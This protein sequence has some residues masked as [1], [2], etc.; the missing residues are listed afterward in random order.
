MV[1]K[2]RAVILIACEAVRSPAVP[3]L[4]APAAVN[5]QTRTRTAENIALAGALL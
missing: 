3:V 5:P 4:T 2:I 1:L